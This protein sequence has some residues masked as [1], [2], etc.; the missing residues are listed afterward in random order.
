MNKEESFEEYKKQNPNI[1]LSALGPHGPLF[2]AAMKHKLIKRT[3]AKLAR[4]NLERDLLEF[5]RKTHD[6]GFIRGLTAAKEGK[7]NE[8][9]TGDRNNQTQ[10]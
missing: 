6:Y 9:N 2:E 4:P 8:D 5:A 7:Q 3:N 10:E 1:I